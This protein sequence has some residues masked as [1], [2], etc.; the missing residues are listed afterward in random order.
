MLNPLFLSFSFGAGLAAFFSPCSVALL[1][2]Y[3]TYSF[4]NKL[5]ETWPAK[6]LLTA[7]RFGAIAS[8]GFFAVFGASG[9]TILLLG[10]SVKAAI[11]GIAIATG[12]ALILAGVL[13]V[14]GKKLNIR[15]GK[16]LSAIKNPK[17]SSFIFGVAYAIA[18]LS[19]TFPLFLSVV[20]Q[21]IADSS[22]TNGLAYL[23]AYILGM[24]AMMTGATVAIIVAR[25]VAEKRIRSIVPAIEKATPYALMAAGT[26]MIYYQAGI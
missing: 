11:P 10:N 12:S 13:M 18:A 24:S 25:E 26:Y 6:K 9:G 4:S 7:A 21:G 16:L 3:V 22:R 19:C 8:L 2:S 17:R 14:A 15:A 1:P 23:L 5:K 20:L